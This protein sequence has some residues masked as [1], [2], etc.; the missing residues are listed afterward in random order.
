MFA[1]SDKFRHSEG[2]ITF[3]PQQPMNATKQAV[4][5]WQVLSWWPSQA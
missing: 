2:V 5:V 3:A 4:S 1:T